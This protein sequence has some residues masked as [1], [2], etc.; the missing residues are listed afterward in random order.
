MFAEEEARVRSALGENVV[1]VEH[2]GS[3][4]VCGIAAK[5]IIDIAVAVKERSDGERSVKPLENIGYVYRGEHGIAGRFY[6]VK[7]EPR[8]YHLHMLLS[9]SDAWI[10]HLSFRDYLRQNPAVA[11]EYGNLK[12][13]LAQKYKYD[14]DAY[15]DGKNAFIEKVL[16]RAGLEKGR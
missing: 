13:E 16:K 15:L 5:P 10:N 9:A 14:R 6:F 1:A 3:A 11:R 2:V 8:T 4:S 7:G 12:K